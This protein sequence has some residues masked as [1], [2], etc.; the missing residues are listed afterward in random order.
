VHGVFGV[1]T[2]PE[3]YDDNAHLP[4]DLKILHDMQVGARVGRSA[5]RA[6]VAYAMPIPVAS[7]DM[8]VYCQGVRIH[9]RQDHHPPK[10][11]GGLAIA[12]IQSVRLWDGLEQIAED[13]WPR[14]AY[15]HNLDEM[16]FDESFF[17]L[18]HLRLTTAITVE[19]RADFTIDNKT[20][21]HYFDVRLVEVEILVSGP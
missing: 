8:K 18:S 4:S 7:P 11:T 14:R 15:T 16:L 13:A 2:A 6:T 12:P 3:V 20:P 1:V 17:R 9:A 5:G 21:V 10:A 19:V